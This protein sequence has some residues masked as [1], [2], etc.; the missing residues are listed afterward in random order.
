MKVDARTAGRR[1]LM[2]SY[3]VIVVVLGVTLVIATRG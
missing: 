1:L 3:L 2:G